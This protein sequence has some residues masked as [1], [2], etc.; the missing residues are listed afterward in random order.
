[1]CIWSKDLKTPEEH[2]A[3]F[4]YD[5]EGKLHVQSVFLPF[6]RIGQQYGFERICTTRQV[7]DRED[8]RSI[9]DQ[10]TRQVCRFPEEAVL[11]RCYQADHADGFVLVYGHA[12]FPG[13]RPVERFPIMDLPE[14]VSIHAGSTEVC[15]N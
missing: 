3:A 4:A 11:L 6:F 13:G 10:W 15:R 7:L 12:S 1:M 2:L 8:W 5:T 9:L 14:E